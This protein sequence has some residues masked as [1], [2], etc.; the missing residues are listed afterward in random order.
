MKYYKSVTLGC[1]V[2]TYE[3]QA[4]CQ[5]LNENNYQESHDAKC[6]LVIVN[7]CAV[8]LTSESKSRQKIRSLKKENP[9]AIVF[10]MGCY[11]QLHPEDVASLEEADIIIGTSKRSKVLEYIAKFEQTR[12]QIVDVNK[13]KRDQV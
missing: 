11:S 3:T 13:D 8:T 9:N 2:N 1:K 4:I 5:I 12:E 7:T 10:V 6:D